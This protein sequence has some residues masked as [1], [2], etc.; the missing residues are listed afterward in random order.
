MI[1]F[2]IEKEVCVERCMARTG[3][4]TLNTPGSIKTITNMMSGMKKK[5]KL[6]KV[7]SREERSKA[8]SDF[9]NF[10]DFVI[11]VTS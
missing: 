11:R 3:H 8:T 5:S 6:K 10:S 4:P 1:N 2:E 7:R 9:C